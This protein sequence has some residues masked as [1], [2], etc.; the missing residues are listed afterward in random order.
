MMISTGLLRVAPHSLACLLLI[1]SLL[2]TAACQVVGARPTIAEPG[3]DRGGKASAEP[4]AEAIRSDVVY[5]ASPHLEGRGV[6]TRGIDL[7]ADFIAEQFR[8]L[9]LQP[10]PGHDGYFQT[11]EM[12]VGS[13]PGDATSLRAMGKSLALNEQFRP[14]A[15]SKNDAFSGPVAFVGYGIKAPEHDYDD[16][17]GVDLKDK[18]AL[19]LRYE[20]HHADGTSR[21]AK[22]GS[23]K[24]ARLNEKVR[25]CV[26][27]GASAVIIVNPP[28]HHDE[29]DPLL[30]FRGAGLA[31]ASTP[32][33]TVN[34]ST[35]NEWLAAAGQP[36]LAELQERIDT[37]GKPLS[38]ALEKLRVEG[39]VR[40]EPQK[41]SVKN[42]VA[43]LPGTGRWKDEYVVVG[44]HYD[45]LGLGGIGSFNPNSAEIHHGADDNASGTA[46]LLAL[47][48]RFAQQGPR[49]RSIIFI[50][51]TAEESGLIGS[52]QFVSHP[53][54]PLERIAAMVNLDMV[55]RVRNNVLY[56]GGGGTAGSFQSILANA[57]AE[58][59]LN[60][61]SMGLGGRGP[62]DH[63]SFSGKRIPVLFFFSGLH[64]DYHRPTDT[65]D[66]INFDGI[67]ET[68]KLTERIVSRIVA[69]PREQYVDRYDA[70]GINTNVGLERSVGHSPTTRP[71]NA[72]SADDQ[73]MPARRVRLGVVPEFGSDESTDGMKISGTSANSPASRAGLRGGDRIT[74]LGPY[75]IQNIYD[76]QEALSRLEPGQQLTITLVR[77]GKTIELPLQ[78]ALPEEQQ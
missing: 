26:D 14:L 59:P 13:R 25:R 35:A 6:A 10:I 15:W 77:D 11:F 21:F 63:A 1:L 2:G 54:V 33:L 44:A 68:V 28:K 78:L 48:R 67:V 36:S 41:R 23:S 3:A 12:T 29:L 64:E 75:P 32:V 71:M 34:P 22:E 70:Q 55:G 52:A 49:E 16:F 65:A 56:V 62:S 4:S 42:V 51:F 40:I 45:H 31:R 37:T 72:S 66:K 20:P 61:K 74:R 19:L 47:A 30:P 60:L 76:L 73:R 53:P 50:A 58:S 18:V 27:A 38:F 69:E 43:V 7:A 8:A 46:A 17:A 5:L 9:G 39:E 24:H 57:D